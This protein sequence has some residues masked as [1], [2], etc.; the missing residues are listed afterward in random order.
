MKLTLQNLVALAIYGTELN[1]RVNPHEP[2]GWIK[3]QWEQ[4]KQLRELEAKLPVTDIY[5][6]ALLTQP[7]PANES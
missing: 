5:I 1:L 2:I 4:L 7:T 3:E 6:E